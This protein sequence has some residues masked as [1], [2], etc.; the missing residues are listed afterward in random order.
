MQC[1]G[2]F[3]SS[4]WTL[5]LLDLPPSSLLLSPLCV[6]VG[7]GIAPFGSGGCCGGLPCLCGESDTLDGAFDI[8]CP[9][10]C[11]EH[12]ENSLTLVVLGDYLRIR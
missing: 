7:V 11:T 9:V 12:E 1:T 4:T 8:G 5:L 3:L 2:L 6:N 10:F